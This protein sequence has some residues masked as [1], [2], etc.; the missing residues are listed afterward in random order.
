[1]LFRV[2]DKISKTMTYP[3]T[4]EGDDLYL[5]LEG[6]VCSF[7]EGIDKELQYRGYRMMPLFEVGKYDSNRKLIYDGDL[8]S[9]IHYYNHT[10]VGDI[11]EVYYNN[12]KLSYFVTNGEVD[13]PIR[14]F[15]IGNVKFVV[16]GNIFENSEFK[17]IKN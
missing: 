5:S 8:L 9:F 7:D 2:W 12:E 13:K 11:W 16:V 17:I 14:E 1:M 15:G 3:L 4:G 6:Q 10:L